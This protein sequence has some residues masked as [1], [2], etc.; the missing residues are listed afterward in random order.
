MNEPS[1]IFVKRARVD[2][3]DDVI[4]SYQSRAENVWRAFYPGTRL[5][6]RV[7]YYEAEGVLGVVWV[8]TAYDD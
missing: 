7:T 6:R 2:E 5:T 8:W 4:R 3:S 1:S